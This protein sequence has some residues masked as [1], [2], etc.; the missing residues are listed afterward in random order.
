MSY[1]LIIIFV[2]SLGFSIYFN[3]FLIKRPLKFFI[4]KANKSA[5]RF[6]SQ[7]KPIFGGMS[8][9]IVFFVSMLAVSFLSNEYLTNEYICLFLIVTISFLM[10]LADDIL[11]TPP[12]V[13]FFVQI[14]CAAIL[15]YNGIF[16]KISPND[17][18]NYTITILWVVG[19]MNS[20]NML[21][22][23]DGVSSLTSLSIFLTAFIYY[24]YN[25][26]DFLNLN[27]IILIS[28]IASLLGFIFYNWNPSK[29]YMGDN[30]S[31]F[32]G[33]LL[34]W[35]GIEFFWNSMPISDLSYGFNTMQFLIVLLAFIV[36]ITDTTTV[37]INRILQKKS[38][39]V[40]GKDHTTH[41][42]YYLGFSVRWVAITFF[43]LNI[44]GLI[45]A[46]LL[47]RYGA[48]ISYSNLW[49]FFIYPISVFL[50]LYLNTKFSKVK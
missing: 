43:I 8:F 20:I 32:L 33:I 5:I 39:F 50:F 16:I 21:D 28:T 25:N 4:K 40:G 15:I 49:L 23:M 42:L 41:H 3:H 6:S 12:Q 17:W 24:F 47:I 11:S 10:G 26:F 48:F 18:V 30:G 27:S 34:A 35:A 29:M 37:T 14:L 22:N 13:K 38:P 9:Y 31:Q 7:S 45:L 44:I 1:Y 2:I 46:F 36:M 19:I